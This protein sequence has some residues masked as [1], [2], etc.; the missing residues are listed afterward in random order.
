MG[1]HEDRRLG[2]GGSDIAAVVGLS[3]FRSPFD[4]WLEKVL[5]KPVSGD[6]P[7]DRLL[8][9]TLMEPVI[10][11]ILEIKTGVVARPALD[12]C[13]SQHQFIHPEYGFARAHIDG[14]A[15]E[16]ES[17]IWG[18]KRL[19]T[20]TIVECKNV[21]HFSRD[22]WGDEYSEEIPD[23]YFIQAQWNM[24]VTGADFCYMPILIGGNE[25]RIYY[26]KKDVAICEEL[27]EDARR[28]W[29][30][31]VIPRVPPPP[32]N[33]SDARKR[34]PTGTAGKTIQADAELIRA[35]ERKNNLD[36]KIKALKDE[37]EDTKLEIMSAIGDAEIAKSGKSVVA[38][39]KTGTRKSL[40]INLLRERHSSVCEECLTET[41][42]RTL[43]VK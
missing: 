29:F 16:R 30:D 6:S 14:A 22:E 12:E 43:R 13:G 4:V 23:Q 15:A 42:S 1:F 11:K 24:F 9:G 21:S 32:T 41:S 7:D 10:L 37:L 35:C 8:M 40:D 5:D 26:I 18:G 28:F 36:R 27:L 2:V 38:T 25:P 20:D 17:E 31:H 34:W 3:P 39:W 33:T 19:K